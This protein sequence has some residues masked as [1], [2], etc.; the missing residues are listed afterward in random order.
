MIR[1]FYPIYELN[2]MKFPSLYEC[3]KLTI[4]IVNCHL[5]TNPSQFVITFVSNLHCN[6]NVTHV[7]GGISLAH[8][9]SLFF[10]SFTF[11]TL[12]ALM[13]QHL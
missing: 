11:V 7:I 9:F 3:T 10:V 13:I 5:T 12:N 2:K 4:A 6:V 8:V 1:K